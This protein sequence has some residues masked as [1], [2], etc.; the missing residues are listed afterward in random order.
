MSLQEYADHVRDYLVSHGWRGA[1]PARIG[2]TFKGGILMDVGNGELVAFLLPS[3]A[4]AVTEPVAR[5]HLQNRLSV[6][7]DGEYQMGETLH[8][9]GVTCVHVRVGVSTEAHAPAA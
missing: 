9:D 7:Y 1:T 2:G 3:F 6:W 4:P 8:V 5:Q